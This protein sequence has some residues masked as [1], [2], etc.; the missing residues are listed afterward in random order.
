[1]RKLIL[2]WTVAFALIL[3]YG[4]FKTVDLFA[5]YMSKQNHRTV[6]VPEAKRF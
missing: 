1:M 5:D 4:G 3:V 6:Y 2:I